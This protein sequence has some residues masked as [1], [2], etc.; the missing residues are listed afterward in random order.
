MANRGRVIRHGYT[1]AK[2][3]YVRTSEPERAFILDRLNRGHGT[4]EIV[5]AFFREF[6]RDTSEATVHD[7][8]R[9]NHG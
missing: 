3:V 6:G 8:R 2:R 1:P 4:R 9:A 7:M 5:R